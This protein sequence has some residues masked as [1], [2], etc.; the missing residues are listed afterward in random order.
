MFLNKAIGT[1]LI[2]GILVGAAMARPDLNAFI[3]KSVNTTPQLVSQAKNDPEVMDRYMRHYGMTR[4][5]VLQYLGSLKP[6]T[7]KEE[8]VYAIYSVP[9]GGRIKL[10]MERLKKGHRIFASQDGEPQLVLKCGNPL[11]MG[12]KSVVAINRTPVTTTEIVVEESPLEIMTQIES[13]SEPLLALQPAEPQYTLIT[14]PDVDPIQIPVLG[15]GFN[16]LPLA[17]GGLLFIDTGSSSSNPVPEPMTMAVLGAGMAYIGMR[18][19]RK[20]SK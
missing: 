17:L 3:N 13:E 5:E 12:P 14:P 7:L 1:G 18:K 19:R 6:D 16:P 15:G 4:A 9:E 2:F 10:H 11:T 20:A 8:G